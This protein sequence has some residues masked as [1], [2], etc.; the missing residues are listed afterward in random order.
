LAAGGFLQDLFVVSGLTMSG[1]IN[2]VAAVAR[3]ISQGEDRTD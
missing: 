2:L 1:I 3:I